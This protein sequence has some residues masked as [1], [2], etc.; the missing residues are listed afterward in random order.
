MDVRGELTGVLTEIPASQSITRSSTGGS[1]ERMFRSMT[2]L[3]VTKSTNSL[4]FEIGSDKMLGY[5]FPVRPSH[6][7]SYLEE[8]EVH[9]PSV[10]HFKVR[11]PQIVTFDRLSSKQKDVY[12]DDAGPPTERR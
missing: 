10:E 5:L 2:E 6:I 12:I 4:V 1:A 11:N 8:R 9:E 7:R 3:Q